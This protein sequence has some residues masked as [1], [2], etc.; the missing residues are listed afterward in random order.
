M[1][2][3][4]KI[5]DKRLAD[6]RIKRCYPSLFENEATTLLAFACF[7]YTRAMERERVH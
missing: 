6:L 7:Q 4:E 3:Y 1:D 2:D 5:R